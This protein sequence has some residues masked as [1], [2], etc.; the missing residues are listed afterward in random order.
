VLNDRLVP[1]PTRLVESVRISVYKNVDSTPDP[2]TNT[3]LGL[4]GRVYGAQ[5]RLLFDGLKHGGLARAPDNAPTY[6]VLLN[7]YEDWGHFGRQQSVV[8]TC[9]HCHLHW[10]WKRGV[11]SLN[12]IV[13]FVPG[14]GMPGIV[15]PMGYGDVVPLPRAERIARW[16]QRQEDYLRL[17]EY[18]R[19]DDQGER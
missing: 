9:V 11:F 8:Q 15:I 6:G 17:V 10:K 2:E 7:G 18:A 16:K 5:R 14:G 1:V 12:T 13:S 3:G 19:A 4:I